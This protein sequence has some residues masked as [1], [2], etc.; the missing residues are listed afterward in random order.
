MHMNIAWIGTGVMGI[1]MARNLAQA[2]HTVRVY[3]RTIEKCEPLKEFGIEVSQTIGAC[4][5]GA[6]AV[7]TIVGYPKDVEQVYLGAGGIFE[8]A[9][10]GALLI[11]M[12][13]SSPVLAKKL[14]SKALSGD[15]GK[16]FRILDAPVS[17]GDTGAKNASLSIMVGGD[18][19]DF[20]AAR[21]LFEILGK[22]SVYLGTAG[23]GQNCKACNQV[24]IAGTIAGCAEAVIYAK[25]NGLDAQ[26]VLVAI[27][28]GAAG[29][30]QMDNNAP[31]MIVGDYEPGFFNK[32][33]IKDMGIARDVMAEQGVKL[34][35]LD[36]VL[37][38]YETLAA[39]G[40]GDEGT[41]SLIEQYK[42]E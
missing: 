41:Q 16:K 32:H 35:V 19:A 36:I 3:S 7:F 18:E 40:M 14:H 9:T 11:D 4:V 34:P 20:D 37:E 28:K 10:D 17:G 38:M 13:T 29:S 21:P 15:G 30:W 31:K 25:K 2:G 5:K 6:Q 24:A 8:H 12:T 1:S 42:S 26:A 22:N 39:K 23:S 33:F 27:S